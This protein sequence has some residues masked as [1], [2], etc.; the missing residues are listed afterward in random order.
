MAAAVTLTIE[1]AIIYG[2][3]HY[4]N[5]KG[6]HYSWQRPYPWTPLFFFS[7]RRVGRTLS[8]LWPLLQGRYVGFARFLTYSF[9]YASKFGGFIP[10]GPVA[11]LDPP[12]FVFDRSAGG[13]QSF[14]TIFRRSAIETMGAASTLTM[15][16]A[17]N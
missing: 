11:P 15:R 2:S 13:E 12:V 17:I 14:R 8:Y 6:G 4:P 3:G 5:D 9:W 1:A 16:A 7:V 10:R